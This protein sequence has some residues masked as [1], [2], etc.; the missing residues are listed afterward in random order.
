MDISDSLKS[1]FGH[2]M[3]THMEVRLENKLAEEMDVA[4]FPRDKRP[5]G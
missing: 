3:L 5:C 1:R 4:T 2:G